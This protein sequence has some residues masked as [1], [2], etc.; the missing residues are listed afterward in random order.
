LYNFPQTPQEYLTPKYPLLLSV[1]PSNETQ[2]AQVLS[3][4][5]AIADRLTPTTCLAIWPISPG[6]IDSNI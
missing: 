4:T 3:K 6:V 5:T 2:N 1:V